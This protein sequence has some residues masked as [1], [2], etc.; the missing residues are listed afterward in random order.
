VHDS[1]ADDFV[2]RVVEGI[3]KVTVGAPTAEGSEVGPMI[4][5]GHLDKV[6]GCVDTAV[7]DGATLLAGGTRLSGPGF[8]HGNFV[9]P[10]VLDNVTATAPVFT[11][12]IFGPVLTV[13]RFSDVD[14]AITLAN[15]TEYGL[16]G[17]IWT[18]N[19]DKALTTARRMRSGRVWVNT[20]IDGAPALPAGGMKQSG[21]GREMGQAGFDEFTELKTIQIRTGTRTPV[22][23]SLPLSCEL[24]T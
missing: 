22:F 13:T 20:T 11:E 8:E 24:V 3:G 23:P 7:A 9:A 5:A 19:I 4:H 15:A 18:K 2:A 10:T 21:Y 6:L 12:E 16:A 1:I 14:E 17:S